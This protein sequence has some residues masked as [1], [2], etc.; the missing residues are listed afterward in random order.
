MIKANTAARDV[1]NEKE[2]LDANWRRYQHYSDRKRAE[3]AKRFWN[4]W[5]FTWF[6]QLEFWECVVEEPIA[7]SKIKV[8]ELYIGNTSF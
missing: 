2:E 4:H 3:I 7:I 5:L 1:S 6:I 8:F